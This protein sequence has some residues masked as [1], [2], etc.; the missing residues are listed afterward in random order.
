MLLNEFGLNII[1]MPCQQPPLE[2]A[3]GVIP[4]NSSSDDHCKALKERVW[5][6]GYLGFGVYLSRF[7]PLGW[8]L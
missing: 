3:A 6:D 2:F 4:A 5:I 7:W 8:L 1:I